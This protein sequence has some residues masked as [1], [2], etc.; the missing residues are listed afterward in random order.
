[1]FARS[2]NVLYRSTAK[3]SKTIELL[4]TG[5][6]FVGP[7]FVGRVTHYQLTSSVR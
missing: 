4:F 5:R 1:M 6:M 2:T 3:V 7:M